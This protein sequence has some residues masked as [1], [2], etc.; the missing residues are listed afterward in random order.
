MKITDKFTEVQLQS[1]FSFL[2]EL[3]KCN[4]NLL[5]NCKVKGLKSYIDK[6]NNYVCAYVYESFGA[7]DGKT[8]DIKYKKIDSNG[9]ITDLM[10]LYKNEQNLNDS[11]SKMEEINI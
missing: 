10:D 7:S 3:D 9:E 4:S 6:K 5:S 1:M 2:E 11:I 8:I